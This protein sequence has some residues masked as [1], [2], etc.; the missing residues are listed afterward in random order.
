M[1]GELLSAIG[2]LG[3][4][5]VG[6]LGQGEMLGWV[7]GWVVLSALPISSKHNKEKKMEILCFGFP[8]SPF[9]SC[10]IPNPIGCGFHDEKSI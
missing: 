3:A 8:G 2:S 10:L 5:L 7:Q 9:A 1:L 6:C 4:L